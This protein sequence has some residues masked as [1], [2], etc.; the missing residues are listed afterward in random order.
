[1]WLF[2]FLKLMLMLKASQKSGEEKPDPFSECFLKIFNR[3]FFS[4][5][6]ELSTA[7]A[8]QQKIKT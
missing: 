3:S 1:M 7:L 2:L 8:K 4:S 6:A 5:N